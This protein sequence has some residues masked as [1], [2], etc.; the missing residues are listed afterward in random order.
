[1]VRWSDDQMARS[2]DDDPIDARSERVRFRDSKITV[3]GPFSRLCELPPDPEVF[4]RMNFQE[5]RV[6]VDHDGAAE[7]ERGSH[8]GRRRGA[9]PVSERAGLDFEAEVARRKRVRDY[10]PDRECLERDI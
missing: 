9:N 8:A 2:A 4:V 6:G 1:M 10:R 7:R 5:V 3:A